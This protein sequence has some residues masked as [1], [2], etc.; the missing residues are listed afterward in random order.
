MK[1]F[2]TLYAK[3][4]AA[5]FFLLLVMAVAYIGITLWSTRMY[6]LDAHY[7]LHHD[8]ARSFVSEGLIE[9]GGKIEEKRLKEIF[10]TLML[11][12]PSIEVYLTDTTGELLAYSAPPGKVKKDR[13]D[14]APIN[15]FLEGKD[16]MPVWGDDPRHPE[17]K[18][19][20]SV[21]P[22]LSEDQVFCGYLYVILEGE[23]Y[24]SALEMFR[25]SHVARLM[26][27]NTIGILCAIFLLGLFS[28]FWI[29]RR[30]HRLSEKVDAFRE[31]DEIAQPQIQ[32]D[33]LDHLSQSFERMQE[34]ITQ[35]VEHIHQSDAERRRMVENISHDLRTPLS[36]M[37]GHLETLLLK[38]G[39]VDEEQ[40]RHY[41][42]VAVAN[43]RRL[44]R[45]V[46]ELFE[47]AHL[48]APE[49]KLQLES[50]NLP[51]LAQDITQKFSGI[52]ATKRVDLTV[53]PPQGS[54]F[55]QADVA[56][57]E[58]VFENL[59]KNAIDHITEEGVITISFQQLSD[60]LLETRISDTGFGI[61][62]E[63]IGRIFD[64]FY[65]G[66]SAPARKRDG[67]GLGLAIVKR[68]VELHGGTVQAN[69]A[70]EGGA[71]FRFSL[72]VPSIDST[73]Q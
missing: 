15:R 38:N 25:T 58:R 55:V 69:N 29:T 72:P 71:I 52:V 44:S 11:V 56:L 13:I 21:A 10:H 16:P 40:R 41:L 36:S 70:T 31:E 27:T 6:Q 73:S 61:P 39:E 23:S 67:H 2:R 18:A 32:G 66:P 14:L 65:R 9:E 8:L 46:D 43:S 63:D 50:I 28:F 37:Q 22:V 60:E 4:A 5:L 24:Q 20:F 68:I 59:I 30:L 12:N 26:L 3:L 17:Q 19:L 1:L 34:R 47:L 48:D 7:R 49:L 51:E 35:Q 57:V 54:G 33:E 45:L 53:L 42:E 64:R 62:E